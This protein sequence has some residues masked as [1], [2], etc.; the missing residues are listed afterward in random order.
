V[1]RQR[2]RVCLI[3]LPIWFHRVVGMAAMA[4]SAD[5]CPAR[6]RSDGRRTISREHLMIL[7]SLLIGLVACG[8][9]SSS[10]AATVDS[11]HLAEPVHVTYRFPAPTLTTVMIE[12]R[13]YTRVSLVGGERGG[14]PGHPALPG[15]GADVLLP[16]G[17]SLAGVEIVPG[18]R[19]SLG[20][21]L[22]VEPVGVPFRL[23][24]GPDSV[25]APTP[26]PVV[27][28]GNGPLPP[29]HAETIGTF[30]FRGYQIATFDLNPVRYVPS[31][32][33]LYYYDSFE[34]RVNTREAPVG[35]LYRNTPR[36]LDAVVTRVDNPD[37]VLTYGTPRPLRDEG[38]DMLIVTTPELAASFEPL[39]TAHENRGL[40]T[41]IRTTDDIGG[42]EASVVRDYIRSA[43]LDD[44]IEYVLI[45]A[46]D[47]L[48]PACDLYVKAW[49][50][51]DVETAMPGDIY[52]A[53]LD[54]DWNHDGD[55]RYGEPNDG[56]G[57]GEVD[58]LAEV[59]VG[60]APVGTAAEA[61]RFVDK[62]LHVITGS[63]ANADEAL[64]LGEYLGFGG[65]SDYAKPMMEQLV[66][67]CS[68]DGYS[69][70][71][72]PSDEFD[73]TRL[74]DR[75]H[76]W[77][78]SDLATEINHGVFII[79]HLG[80]GFVDW[81]MKFDLADIMGR[82]R[83]EEP[84]FIYSQA[85][86]AGHFDGMDCWA[87][88]ANIKSAY[89]AFAVVMN[90]RYG[91]GLYNSTDGPSQ[92]Y[93]R[94]FWDAVFKDSEDKPELGRANT[95]SKEDNRFKVNDP[96]MRWCMYEINLFGDPALSF[97]ATS[98]VSGIA[99]QLVE[100]EITQEALDDEPS[101]RYARTFDLQVEITEGDDWESTT[102]MAEID[103]SFY[104]H[105]MFDGDVPQPMLWGAFPS[106]AYDSF[107]SARDFCTPGFTQAP[108]ITD[109]VMEA[110]WFDSVNTGD[111]TYTIARFTV[112]AG[113]TLHIVGESTAKYTGAQAHAFEFTKAVNLPDACAGDFNLDGV[114]DIS[115][116]G[117]LLACFEVD[118][119]ADMDDDGDT[120]ISD[121]GAF[122]AVFEIPCD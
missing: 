32:G 103:G 70:V 17:T 48:L 53:G 36:D 25:H 5:Y 118:P 83:N 119:G 41:E 35:D 9:A 62:T 63:H 77:T 64:M 51:G 6:R 102:V 54:G 84:V 90:A 19:I 76:E 74:Y 28:A 8:V 38:Y 34:V 115:D 43:Y 100:V 95:D 86:L 67:G 117:Y 52:F 89:G 80:H 31:T 94:Q 18:R 72:I 121:L 75:D 24:D 78:A 120:D 45:G 112:N 71:G 92:R 111:G 11:E 55:G 108:S 44:G 7:R 106:L 42:S 107:F 114:R 4:S 15:V 10:L 93:H 73:I 20:T 23:S 37:V 56:P 39:K 69:T 96:C 65:L 58:L 122:L 97:F 87:E 110:S 13:A 50:G 49:D 12:G 3:R 40:R 29:V 2:S 116:L 14:Q 109:S 47:N 68:A 99:H 46:D 81:A 104:Q 113:E 27:Y 82:L 22:L 59:Y 91:W 88:Y 1:A 21:G 57:G 101:L 60:R 98:Q 26:D 105:P 61:E 85:C 30:G 79:N 16:L 33:E 66:D